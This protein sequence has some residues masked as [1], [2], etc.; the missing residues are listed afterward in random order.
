MDENTEPKPVPDKNDKLRIV[1]WL[2]WIVLHQQFA[3]RIA[4][5]TA[6]PTDVSTYPWFF[7]LHTSVYT[8]SFLAVAAQLSG[9]RNIFLSDL[10]QVLNS[11]FKLKDKPGQKYTAVAEEKFLDAWCFLALTEKKTTGGGKDAPVL[12]PADELFAS[13]M[14][15]ELGD[16]KSPETAVETAEKHVKTLVADLC[17]W[18]E[19]LKKNA[20]PLVSSEPRAGSELYLPTRFAVGKRAQPSARTFADLVRSYPAVSQTEHRTIHTALENM[21]RI[22]KHYGNYT[23]KEVKFA[24]IFEKVTSSSGKVKTRA[25]SGESATEKV[26][27]GSGVP[28]TGLPPKE[29]AKRVT[30]G[31]EDFIFCNFRETRDEGENK[32]R[33]WFG[34]GPLSDS[35]PSCPVE[36]KELDAYLQNLQHILFTSKPK[37]GP[38]S[39]YSEEKLQLL[40]KL[41]SRLAG[42]GLLTPAETDIVNHSVLAYRIQIQAGNQQAVL[43]RS[44]LKKTREGLWA[45]LTQKVLESVRAQV[46]TQLWK[47]H[48]EHVDFIGTELVER[49]DSTL[50]SSQT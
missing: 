49:F 29:I 50:R 43:Q 40:E 27:D 21:V 39:P 26:A 22:Q 8:C 38:E 2:K 15:E 45:E 36:P 5:N 44:A 13:F 3:K 35:G 33:P 1:N 16:I 46:Q 47:D 23:A 20:T 24:N 18:L 17:H 12:E 11:E 10:Q 32:C 34:C 30:R 6:D 25:K 9:N 4:C 7:G 19:E 48:D 37:S 31:V 41:A 28:A 42:K 14:P